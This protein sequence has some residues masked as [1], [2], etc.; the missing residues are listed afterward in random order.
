VSMWKDADL[1][2]GSTA[3]TYVVTE[4]LANRLALCAKAILTTPDVLVGLVF[5]TVVTRE[6][7]NYNVVWQILEVQEAAQV[8]RAQRMSVHSEMLQFPSHAVF[9]VSTVEVLISP[10]VTFLNQ[11]LDK[12]GLAKATTVASFPIPDRII[13]PSAPI[14]NG[15]ARSMDFLLL[16]TKA[17][18]LCLCWSGR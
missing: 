11:V 4:Q 17:A 2:S 18:C 9:S 16:P 12:M 14:I 5:I 7:V 15:A 3:A 8:F 10:T 13:V 1:M 6:D